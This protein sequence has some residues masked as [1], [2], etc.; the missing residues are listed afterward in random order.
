MERAVLAHECAHAENNDPA[1][2][3]PRNESRANLAAAQR[4]INPREWNALTRV[5]GDYDR[6]CVDLGITRE[7]F[8][9]YH[10]HEARRAA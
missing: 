9:A 5:Y 10:E 8:I 1:G 4:L 7:Q 2:H 3:H 6:I